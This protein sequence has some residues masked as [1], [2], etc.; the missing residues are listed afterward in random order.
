MKFLLL[1][2]LAVP[3]LSLIRVPMTK[4]HHELR[5][6]NGATLQQLYKTKYNTA[7]EAKAYDE[8]L[9][10]YQ[11]AQYYGSINIGTPGQSFKVIFDTGSSNLW[12][13][14]KGCPF[15]DIACLLHSKFDCKKSSTCKGTD[16]PFEIQYGSGSM[17]GH[18]DYDKVC[19]EAGS[20]EICCDNQGFAC[21]TSEP[22]AAFVAA[23]FDGILG[24][25]FDNISVQ[26]LPTPFTCIMADKAK[27][28]S[29]VFAFYLNRD[30][31]AG[32]A[33]GGEMTL[34]GIDEA[35]Y[36]GEITYVPIPTEM[37]GYWEFNADAMRIGDIVIAA[38]TYKAIAD[39]GTSLMAGPTDQVKKIQEAIGATPI[40]AGEYT[41]DCNKLGSM[42]DL[43]ITIG[44]RD[45]VLKPVDYILKV[46][47]LGQTICI[48]GFMGIDIPAP[49]GPL[50]ILGDVFIGKFYTVFDKDQ[51]R[52]GFA[53][54]K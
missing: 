11:N 49:R 26:A 4:L 48:S 27:C 44:G 12:V 33:A 53:T 31:S 2:L 28:P 52:I 41:V 25:G 3:A 6:F 14:C 30:T 46:S 17:K 40:I 15:S 34:C 32:A 20:D 7:H 1:T 21:A 9:T 22:G 42:P 45:F 29:G 5:D 8:G 13:P 36:T 37:Q 39:T 24:L 54:A 35:H 16:K 10:D 23:K 38:S 50:W 43:T 19:F 18:V 47:S 51:S